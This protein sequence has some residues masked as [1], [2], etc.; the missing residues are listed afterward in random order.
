[1]ISDAQDL[2][3]IN[4]RFRGNDI[5]PFLNGINSANRW[6][7]ILHN[8]TVMAELETHHRAPKLEVMETL[9]KDYYRI[10]QNLKLN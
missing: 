9:S 5:F 10:L 6:F 3:E 7:R 1:V 8:L 4:F 2:K